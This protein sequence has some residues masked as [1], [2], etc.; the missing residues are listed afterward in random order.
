MT[1]MV[2]IRLLVTFA[3]VVEVRTVEA[4]MTHTSDHL[5]AVSNTIISYAS[6]GNAYLIAAIAHSVML[7]IPTSREQCSC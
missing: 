3:A 4:F 1:A 6:R 7:D 5:S 2:E